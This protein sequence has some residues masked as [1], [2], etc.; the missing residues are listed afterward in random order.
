MESLSG[1]AGDVARRR[2]RCAGEGTD[3][4]GLRGPSRDI[5]AS[6]VEFAAELAR[7]AA[8]FAAEVERLFAAQQAAPQDPA[9]AGPA[10]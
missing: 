3:R 8:R 2:G 1:R 4:A 7:E 10:A 6:V 5:R 9:A